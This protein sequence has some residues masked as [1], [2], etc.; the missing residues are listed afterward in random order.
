MKFQTS[1]FVVSDVRGVQGEVRVAFLFDE[2]GKSQAVK[3]HIG[4]TVVTRDN[5]RA[6]WKPC[7]THV[8]ELIQQVVMDRE[9]EN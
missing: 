5:V 1:I 6:G 4:R 7:K 9:R 3:I 2:A 8:R